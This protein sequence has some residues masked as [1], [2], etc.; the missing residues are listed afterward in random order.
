MKFFPYSPISMPKG[1]N[2]LIAGDKYSI[3]EFWSRVDEDL[4]EGLSN[5]VGCYIF[6][7]RA[8]KGI[9]PWYVGLAAKQPFRK[10]CFTSHKLN[11]YNQ[12]IASRKGTPVLTLIPK[13]TKGARY[14]KASGSG[15]LDIQFLETMLIGACI[16]RNADL[17]NI[18]DT[19]LLREM[20]VPGLLNNSKGRGHSSVTEFKDLLGL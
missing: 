13:C 4:D 3:S 14:A 19:K 17:L 20:S 7:I 18:R 1:T 15:H 9:K 10:E 8:G 2:G 16:R 11:H 5:A 12:A 6:S